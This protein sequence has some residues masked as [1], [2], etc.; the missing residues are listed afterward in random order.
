MSTVERTA[1]ETIFVYFQNVAERTPALHLALPI[2]S[3]SN[4]YALV[5]FCLLVSPYSQPVRSLGRDS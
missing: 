5:L 4:G 2:P 3:T 1:H